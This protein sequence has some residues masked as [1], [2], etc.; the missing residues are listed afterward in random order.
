[1]NHIMKPYTKGMLR[2]SRALQASEADVF[3]DAMVRR[4][5]L[6]ARLLSEKEREAAKAEQQRRRSEQLLSEK[7]GLIQRLQVCRRSPLRTRRT[8]GMALSMVLHLKRATLQIYS[9]GLGNCGGSP[10]IR[11]SCAYCIVYLQQH[12]SSC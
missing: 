10:R 9:N 6:T 3:A 1:M 7:D 4:N 11:I 12:T 5:E 2:H 8:H